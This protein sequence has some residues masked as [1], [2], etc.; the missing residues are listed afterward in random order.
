MWIAAFFAACVAAGVWL[1]VSNARKRAATPPSPELVCPHCQTKGHVVAYPVTTKDGI[2]GAKATGAI[3]T[4]GVSL[5][6]TGLSRKSAKT[7]MLCGNCGVEW[8][9]A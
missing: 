2:S 9:V 3:L 6:G 1:G 4:A 8:L 5:L 7:R